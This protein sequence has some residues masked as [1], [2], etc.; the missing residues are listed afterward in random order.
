MRPKDQ[1]G[2]RGLHRVQPSRPG[3]ISFTW[4]TDPAE[5]GHLARGSAVRVA[6]KPEERAEDV[7]SASGIAVAL[8]G[9]KS[10]RNRSAQ[11]RTDG[12]CH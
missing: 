12:K 5:R 7:E 10:D 4:G 6:I 3:I 1:S 2:D 9:Q 8:K 11:Q